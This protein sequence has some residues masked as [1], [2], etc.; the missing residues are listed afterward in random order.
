MCDALVNNLVII[1]RK[2]QP[3]KPTCSGYSHLS[4]F[5]FCQVSR[6]SFCLHKT[7]YGFNSMA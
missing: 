6:L 5:L 3:V 1:K 7:I 2:D 4:F